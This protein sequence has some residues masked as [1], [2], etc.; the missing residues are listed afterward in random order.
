MDDEAPLT[1]FNQ[2][3]K[4]SG[5][6]SRSNSQMSDDGPLTSF[7]QT[8]KKESRSRTNTTSRSM[9]PVS[10]IPRSKSCERHQ[11]NV[12]SNQCGINRSKSGDRMNNMSKVKNT[13]S[14][15]S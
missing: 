12:V 15:P 1:S 4:K 13:P 14:T 5:I 8:P 2:S 9:I 7:N 10:N 6:R 3:P 11:A